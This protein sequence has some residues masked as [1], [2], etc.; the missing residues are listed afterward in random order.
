MAGHRFYKI[1][2]KSLSRVS[3]ILNTLNKPA[4]VP[5]A[6][7]E[8]AAGVRE[9]LREKEWGRGDFRGSLTGKRP[10][11]ETL[12]ESAIE[13]VVE[14]AKQAANKKRDKAAD[15]GTTVHECIGLHL[16]GQPYP[17]G[18]PGMSSFL[19]WY[20]ASNLWFVQSEALVYDMGLMVAGTADGI[21]KTP[22]GT[23]ILIDYKTG[24]IYKEAALQVSAYAGM[25][26]KMNPQ[27]PI[28]GCA[29]VHLDTE[30]T[31]FE[32]KVVKDWQTLYEEGFVPLAT[33]H[34]RLKG[35]VFEK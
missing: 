26:T 2:G 12:N 28:G 20:E 33:T 29:V 30:E 1:D 24:G 21:F 10:A 3:T 16:G 25:W 27:Q 9:Y 5:W 32:V 18:V 14:A 6:I 34:K 7:K 19:A 22:E 31:G 17:D 4:L 13:E 15:R 8:T 23:F 11:R 35:D